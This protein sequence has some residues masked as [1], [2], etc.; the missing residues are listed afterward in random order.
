MSY[1]D[2][3]GRGFWTR[4]AALETVLG[5][6][7]AELEPLSGDH[8]LRVVL[9]Q[10]SLQATA[11]FNGCVSAE[12]DAN[13]AEPTLPSVVA[14]GIRRMLDRLPADGLVN[15]GDAVFMQRAIS[16]GSGGPCRSPSA[17]APWVTQVAKT[18]L[19][20]IE[21]DLPATASDFWFVDGAGRRKLPRIRR[22]TPSP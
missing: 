7:V 20:L 6:L 8:A 14:A 18:L 1:V 9:D 2:Y 11:G 3:R 13:L 12:L 10:W 19:E 21:G 5:L 15:A 4:D 16:V 17:L 22:D